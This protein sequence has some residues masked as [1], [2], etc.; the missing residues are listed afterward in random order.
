MYSDLLSLP[1]EVLESILDYLDVTSLLL[2]TG[3]CS[4]LNN[5][6]SESPR[7]IKKLTLK[8][9]ENQKDR[10]HS[11]DEENDQSLSLL[12][13][14]A[15]INS[16]TVICSVLKSR[17]KYK[18]IV[19]SHPFGNKKTREQVKQILILFSKSVQELT[20]MVDD[21]FTKKEIIEILNSCVNLKKCTL[22]FIYFKK[23]DDEFESPKLPKMEELII[24]I[25]EP[26]L[27]GIFSCCNK[28]KKL[29]VSETHSNTE[30]AGN[31]QL[32]EEF[33]AKQQQLVDFT[34]IKEETYKMFSTN[35][36]SHINFNLQ[37]LELKGDISFVDSD[38]ALKFFK[39]QTQLKEIDIHLDQDWNGNLTTKDVLKHIFLNKDLQ[40][41]IV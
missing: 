8:I 22:D 11:D 18:K 5:L 24:I 25:E 35:L 2:S 37:R 41:D 19:I 1:D 33:L 34:L 28:L 23:D 3:A 21:S 31:G 20:F 6:I 26:K 27:Y 15:L 17:R 14:A 9:D 38:N 4:K 10:N 13:D 40:R 32:L 30:N 39:T 16:Q 36:L 12:N 29:Y 7:I